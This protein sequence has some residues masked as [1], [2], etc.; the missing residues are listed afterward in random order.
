MQM[1]RACG[2]RFFDDRWESL[3]K[4]EEAYFNL[5]AI[6]VRDYEDPSQSKIC[7]RCAFKLEDFDRFRKICQQVH[8]RLH[9]I[10]TNASEELY[11]ETFTVEVECTPEIPKEDSIENIAANEGDRRNY[12]TVHS[13]DEH[14]P[15]EN[16]DVAGDNNDSYEEDV[17]LE[18]ENAN[19]FKDDTKPEKYDVKSGKKEV[20]FGTDD[21]M[22]GKEEVKSGG[23][24]PGNEN[25]ISEKDYV[26]SGNDNIKS[27]KDDAMPE[28]EEVKSGKKEVNFGTD[29]VKSGKEEVKSGGVKPGNENVISEKDY[30]NSGNDNIRSIEDDAMPEKENVKSGNVEVNTV[31]DDTK[32][33]KDEVS[34]GKDEHFGLSNTQENEEVPSKPKKHRTKVNTLKQKELKEQRTVFSCDLCPKKFYVLLRFNAHKRI[35]DGLKPFECEVCGKAFSKLNNLTLHHTQQHSNNRISLPCDY[36]ECEQKFETQHGLNRHK[37]RVHNPDYTK[38]AQPASICDVCGKRFTT[39]GALKKH[40]YTHAPS[41]M[42]F[43]CGICSKQFPTSYKLKEHT[44]RHEGV[45]NHTCPQCGLGKTSMHEL[46]T[47]IKKMHSAERRSYSCEVCNRHFC[48]TANLGLH[49]KITH[50]GL[51]PFICTVCQFAFGRSDHLKRHMKSHLRTDSL[52]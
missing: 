48:S 20:N 37:N 28:K 44:M 34:S 5:T 38:P 46:R 47:H 27:I 29:D 8:W 32:S 21:V 42:P 10:K 16:E 39:N 26:N 6:Q 17:M 50:L 35:H 30:V 49:V 1:C 2:Q 9:Q 22:S 36:P 15:V 45:K 19:S 7:S 18:K 24:K 3:D 51:K 25:V 40:K 12:D 11:R 43:V 23:V 52:K 14:D 13:G 33:R 41:E 4:Y 31:K